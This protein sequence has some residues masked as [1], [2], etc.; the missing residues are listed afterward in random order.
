MTIKRENQTATVLPSG[1][2]LIAGGLFNGTG[3]QGNPTS[4]AELYNSATNTLPSAQPP[5]R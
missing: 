4:S 1:E 2:V 5:A 3:G